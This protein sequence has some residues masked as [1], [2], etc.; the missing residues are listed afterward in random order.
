MLTPSTKLNR[1]AF[2]L[3][4][5]LI[6]ISIIALLAAI[7]FPVFSRARESARR[8]SCASNLKQIGLGIMQYTQDY[9]ET[10]VRWYYH[11]DTA[12]REGAT[13][14]TT[15]AVER[16]KWMDAIFPYVKNEQIFVCPS[17]KADNIAIPGAVA[18]TYSGRQRYIARENISPT[19]GQTTK[20]GSYVINRGYWNIS[21]PTERVR[22]PLGRRI[23]TVESPATTILAGDGNGGCVFEIRDETDTLKFY[24]AD[25]TPAADSNILFMQWGT[26]SD[27][28]EPNA[29]VQRHLETTNFLYYDGH[30]KARKL[31]DVSQTKFVT[32]NTF[33][34]KAWVYTAFTPGDD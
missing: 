32:Y 10:M 30:V 13:T 6:V 8:S 23:S 9:D 21:S 31:E 26:G 33:G 7:L 14:G 20:W 4:E 17:N 11:S 1:K 22:S 27:H 15:N 25:T 28:D 29:L 5:L 2:T 34:N 24:T 16:Y 18:T 3:I 19:S 12:G